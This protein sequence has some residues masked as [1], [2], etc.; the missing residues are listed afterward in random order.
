MRLY[1]RPA[2]SGVIVLLGVATLAAC[3]EMVYFAQDHPEA[4]R[5]VTKREVMIVDESF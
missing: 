3:E 2:P 5:A 4:V 1:L